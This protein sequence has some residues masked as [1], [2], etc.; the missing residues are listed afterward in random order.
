MQ[1]EKAHSSIV[2]KNPSYFQCFH[3]ILR[4]HNVHKE[5]LVRNI[6]DQVTPA[7]KALFATLRTKRLLPLSLNLH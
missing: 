7:S 3:G 2:R 6:T 1:P 4:K 5:S